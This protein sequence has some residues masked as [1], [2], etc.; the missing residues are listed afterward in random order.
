MTLVY[1]SASGLEQLKENPGSVLVAGEGNT[2]IMYKKSDDAF[3]ILRGNFR[4]SEENVN[5]EVTRQ[6]RQADK[7]HRRGTRL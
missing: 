2:A 6:L 5:R 7:Q 4:G 3:V 1:A